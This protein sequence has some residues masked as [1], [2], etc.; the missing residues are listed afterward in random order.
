M[1]VLCLKKLVHPGFQWVKKSSDNAL[2]H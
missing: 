1:L 2:S